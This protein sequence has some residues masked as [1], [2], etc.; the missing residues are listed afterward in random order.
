MTLIKTD[1]EGYVDQLDGI[2]LFE[3]EKLRVTW[4]DGSV[5]E[6][7]IRVD[8]GIEV[9]VPDGDM[10][11]TLHYI[12]RR[13]F[14]EIPHSGAIAKLYLHGLCA[15]RVNPPKHKRGDLVHF[16]D[17]RHGNKHTGMTFVVVG[18]T[19]RDCKDLG[20][21]EPTWVYSL[22][23]KSFTTEKPSITGLA[24][25]IQVDTTDWDIEKGPTPKETP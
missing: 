1:S 15:E 16:W 9:A 21:V 10:L 5:E 17:D 12:P 23:Q 22:L 13:A 7:A 19:F 11:R 2:D 8:V 4:P 25:P 18:V 24:N 20:S 6:R 14:I 3:A